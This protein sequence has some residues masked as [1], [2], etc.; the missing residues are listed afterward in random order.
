MHRPHPM[1][2]QFSQSLVSCQSC[3]LGVA[4]SG[5]RTSA[6]IPK[7]SRPP[8]AISER[9]PGFVPRIPSNPSKV[10]LLRSATPHRQQAQNNQHAT[11]DLE[12]HH[13]LPQNN[14]T[15]YDCH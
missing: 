4:F 11:D 2:R 8:F 12:K 13:L 5:E 14:P 3:L 7:Q 1:N 9:T 6:C 10:L 15:T